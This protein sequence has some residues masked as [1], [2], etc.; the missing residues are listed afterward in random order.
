M[1]LVDTG[2]DVS[3]VSL[4]HILKHKISYEKKLLGHCTIADGSQQKCLG[5]A[6]I[7]FTLGQKSFTEKFFIIKSL[8]FTLV[9]GSTFMKKYRA[10]PDISGKKLLFLKSDEGKLNIL[11]ASVETDINWD[12]DENNDITQK[13]FKRERRATKKKL[14][15]ILKEYPEALSECNESVPK[16]NL[17]PVDWQAVAQKML[18]DFPEVTGENNPTGNVQDYFHRIKLMEGAKVPKIKTHFY[19]PRTQQLIEEHIKEW[20]RLEVIRPSSSPYN[21]NVVLVGKKGPGNKTRLCIN[22]IPLNKITEKCQAPLPKINLMLRTIGNMKVFSK[23]DLRHGYL[24][25][26]RLYTLTTFIKQLL[27]FNQATMSQSK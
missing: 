9:L 7:T 3:F 2:A 5:S 17:Q 22:Y 16:G 19:P 25:P 23:I 12:R 27:A 14:L 6:C 20:I 4:D 13:A 24:P 1:A 10:L 26:R 21:A 8:N 18:Q 11:P 15:S